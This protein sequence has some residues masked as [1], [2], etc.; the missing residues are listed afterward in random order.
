MAKM[1]TLFGIWFAFCG[2]VAIASTW[3]VVWVILKLM[4]HFGIL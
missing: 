3:F 1:G 4:S 2:I